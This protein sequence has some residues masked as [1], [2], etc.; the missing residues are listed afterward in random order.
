M[1]TNKQNKHIQTHMCYFA[2][3]LEKNI[4]QAVEV[5]CFA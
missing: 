5:V 2:H 3:I 1:V 4:R